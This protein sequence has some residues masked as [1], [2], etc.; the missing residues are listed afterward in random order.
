MRNRLIPNQGDSVRRKWIV[1]LAGSLITGF[2]TVLFLRSAVA[3]GGGR[4][5]A[6]S[7]IRST[8]PAPTAD[9]VNPIGSLILT[10]QG[11]QEVF[12]IRVKN[13]DVTDL[14]LYLSV[15]NF[16]DGTNSSVF[17]FAPM[18]RGNIK[19]G[20]WSRTLT[21][22]GGA[23]PEL[24]LLGIANLT[25]LSDVFS[26][27]IG[28]PGQ[29]NILGGTN[30]IT[31]V[32]TSTNGVTVTT[33]STNIIGGAT[34]VLINVFAWAPVPPI[35]ANSSAF[36]FHKSFTM[37][38]PTVPPDPNAHGNVRLSYNGT[39]GRSLLDINLSGL[40]P[41]Q[42]YTLWLSDAGTNF[43]ANVFSLST[44]GTRGRGTVANLHLDTGVGDSLPIQVPST[45]D[46]TNRVF[47]VRDGTGF[48][49]LAGSLP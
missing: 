40:I 37:V 36:S 46:L 13:M 35:V 23:P 30:F 27:D 25:D 7:Q 28:N 14:S 29:T 8:D 11:G 17:A 22:T 21:G 4:I 26:I 20:S 47:T 49:Y 42:H 10:E 48:I 12:S 32:Q 41:G 39:S 1:L 45:A 18:T 6:R 38:R 3:Q 9:T 2:C 5:V 33:C 15:T 16:F 44:G 24:Q 34:N 31:C 43:G 19:L